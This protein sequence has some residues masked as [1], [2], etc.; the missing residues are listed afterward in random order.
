MISEYE[1]LKKLNLEWGDVG[2]C[3]SCHEDNELGYGMITRVIDELG[4]EVEI[5]CA[6][7]DMLNEN[8]G[9]ETQLKKYKG[10]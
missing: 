5:C 6:V 8:P 3:T 1:L 7:D 2:H 10:E 4:Y 9:L